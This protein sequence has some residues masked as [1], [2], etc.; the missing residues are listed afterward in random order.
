MHLGFIYKKFCTLEKKK[1]MSRMKKNKRR[2]NLKKFLTFLIV[3]SIVVSVYIIISSVG[4]STGTFY[5]D[6]G[7]FPVRANTTISGNKVFMTIEGRI[8]ELSLPYK[9]LTY[10][11]IFVE[12]DGIAILY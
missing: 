5:H 10:S 12:E 9:N 7:V 3:A 4:Y 8:V 1:G 6:S 2:L 11:E